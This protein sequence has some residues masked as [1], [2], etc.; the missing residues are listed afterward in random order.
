MNRSL[1]IGLFLLPLGVV[2]QKNSTT[3]DIALAA[4]SGAFSSAVSVNKLWGF[5]ERGKFKVG[6]GLRLTSIFAKN[7]DYRTAPASLTSGKQSFVALFTEDIAANIDTLR[8]PQSQTNALNLNVHLQYSFSSRLDLGFNIDAI[9]VSFG[10]KQSGEYLAR[11]QG[12]PLSIEAA[13]VT[14]FNLLLVSDSDRGSLNSELYARYWVRPKVGIR[15][16]LSFQFWEYTT[17][18]KLAFN[19]D[20]FRDKI[21][22]PLLAVS[23]RL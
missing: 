3:A 13:K 18:R 20:R 1:I 9:G 19:N 23:F 17:D 5:G 15:A 4:G 7:L 10:G 6:L 16:G 11:S 14:P 2:A 12:R 22:M 8:L 21:L